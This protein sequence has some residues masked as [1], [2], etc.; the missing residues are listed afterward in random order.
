MKNAINPYKHW[1]F[2]M[3][4]EGGADRLLFAICKRH[5]SKG[6]QVMN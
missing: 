4:P 3:L 2:L 1:S 5:R 6:L